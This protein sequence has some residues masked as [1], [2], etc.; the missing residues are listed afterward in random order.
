MHVDAP[1]S[2]SGEIAVPTY[3]RPIT[4]HVNGQLVWNGTHGSGYGAHSDGSY[5]YLSNVP[6]GSNDISTTPAGPP[7]T[8]LSVTAQPSPLAAVA[9]KPASVTIT[10]TGQAPRVLSG[11]VTAAVPTGWTVSPAAAPFTL[12]GTAGPASTTVTVQVTPVASASGAPVPVTFTA[13]AAGLRAR[14]QVSVEPFGSWPAGT[15]ATAS[16]YHAPNTVNGQVRTYDP[17]NALDGDFTTFWNDAT[18]ATYPATLTITSPS[19]VTLPGIA[20][21]SFP[22][23]VPVNFTVATWNGSTWVQQAQITGNDQVY[24]WMPF[25]AP[26]TTSKVQLTVTLDQNTS[27]GEFTRVA[28]LDP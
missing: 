1:A 17:G 6:G 27:S 4:V 7:V 22:D 14:T 9:G 13:T 19:A 15:T 2:T 3:G 24:R 12:D 10:V 26:V 21:A 28:E 8:S 16:S 25:T 5:V 18:P 20:F 23:G 11:S